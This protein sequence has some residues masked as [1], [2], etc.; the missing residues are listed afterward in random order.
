MALAVQYQTVANFTGSTSLYTVPSSGNY[1]T[2]ARD[3]VI[4][5]SGTAQ[6]YFSCGTAS[7][8]SATASSFV[9]PAGGSVVLTQCQVPAGAIVYGIASA[10]SQASIGF[11]TL[12]TVI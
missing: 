2:Y 4:T 8:A 3:L 10:A 7:S 5:N 12:V 11:A 6:A 9:V 1:G